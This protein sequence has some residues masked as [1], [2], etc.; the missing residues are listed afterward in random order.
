MP[1]EIVLTISN[2]LDFGSKLT[3]ITTYRSMHDLITNTNLYSDLNLLKDEQTVDRII[4]KID[5]G[6]LNGSQVKRLWID[7]NKVSDQF[8]DKLS[9]LFPNVSRL[10]GFKERPSYVIVNMETDDVDIFPKNPFGPMVDWINTLETFNLGDDGPELLN[11]LRVVTFPRLT[12]LSLDFVN[13]A[14]LNY[15]V[16]D[17]LYPLKYIKNTPSLRKLTLSHCAINLELLEEIH[18]HCPD[19]ESLHLDQTAIVIKE[20]ALSQPIVPVSLLVQLKISQ[21]FIF[22]RNGL[23]LDYIV[24]KYP[25]LHTLDLDFKSEYDEKQLICYLRCSNAEFENDTANEIGQ[26]EGIP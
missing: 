25:S 6:K 23:L 12:E 18:S 10:V 1:F 24:R 19:I 17:F 20:G 22:D 9:T 7:T 15:A 2:Y 11:T 21:S 3:L 4:K 13:Y 5:D 26:S 14:D 8:Y 16:I